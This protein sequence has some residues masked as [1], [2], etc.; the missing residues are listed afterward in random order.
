MDQYKCPEC[1]RHSYSRQKVTFR[2]KVTKEVING[3]ETFCKPECKA[4]Y[5]AR[6]TQ[7]NNWELIYESAKINFVLEFG[8]MLDEK[9]G[10]ATGAIEYLY[11]HRNDMSK[12]QFEECVIDYGNFTYRY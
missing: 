7:D 6:Q 8:K 4:K 5:L 9:T 2:N 3:Y 1:Q 11:E 10:R 12:D